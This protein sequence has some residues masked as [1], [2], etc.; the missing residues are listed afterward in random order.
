MYDSIILEYKEKNYR[1]KLFKGIILIILIDTIIFFAFSQIFKLNAMWLILYAISVILSLFTGF[2][3]FAKKV[4]KMSK[5]ITIYTVREELYD[6][7][8]ELLSSILN[9]NQLYNKERLREF[10]EY[11]EY[12]FYENKSGREKWENIISTF[13]AVVFNAYTSNGNNFDRCI[14]FLVLWFLLKIN[15]STFLTIIQIFKGK[16]D[17]HYGIKKGINAIYFD[18]CQKR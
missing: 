3:I 9:A 14:E 12:Y 6:Q 18:M 13:I 15:I 16:Y 2:R 10:K 8:E 11:L 4:L 7:E 17:L 1:T 5:K